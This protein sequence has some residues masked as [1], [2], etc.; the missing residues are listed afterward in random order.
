MAVGVK[1]WNRPVHLVTWGTAHT[2]AGG[3]LDMTLALP[4]DTLEL[5]GISGMPPDFGVPLHVTGTVAEPKIEI[6]K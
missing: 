4:A 3:R 1:G 5:M 6:W 2:S